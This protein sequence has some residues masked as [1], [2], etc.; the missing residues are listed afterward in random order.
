VEHDDRGQADGGRPVD[1]GHCRERRA[2]GPAGDA[3]LGGAL[4]GDAHVLI[5]RRRPKPN[6]SRATIANR[7]GVIVRYGP[8]ESK[9]VRQAWTTPIA[10][11]ATIVTTSDSRRPIS[12]ADSEAITRNVSPTMSSPTRVDSSRPV[13]PES[14]PEASHA[15]AST[16]RTGTP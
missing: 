1:T 5:S 13:A 6:Q 10:R 16:R 14:S 7:K 11:P 15:A 2:P 9:G 12:A 4:V 3:H 8:T